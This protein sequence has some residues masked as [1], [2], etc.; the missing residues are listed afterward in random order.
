MLTQVDCFHVIDFHVED[1]HI[2]VYVKDVPVL[3]ED[4]FPFRFAE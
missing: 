1:E 3:L 2:L 4:N